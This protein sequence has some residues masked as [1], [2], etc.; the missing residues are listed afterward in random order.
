MN[1]K[2]TQMFKFLSPPADCANHCVVISE[3]EEM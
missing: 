3:P 1:N 2:S